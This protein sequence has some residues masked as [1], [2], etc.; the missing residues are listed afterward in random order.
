MAANIAT[1]DS[2]KISGGSGVK[3]FALNGVEFLH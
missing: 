1:S 2:D 3:T